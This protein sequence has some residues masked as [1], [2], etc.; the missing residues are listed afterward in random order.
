MFD[1]PTPRPGT[2]REVVTR[3]VVATLVDLLVVFPL[4]YAGIFLFVGRTDIPAP[5]SILGSLF[6]FVFSVFGFMPFFLFR[7]GRPM[8]LFLSAVAVWAVYASVLETLFGQTIGKKLVGLVVV[9]EDGTPASTRAVVV[10]NAFRAIDG[11]VFYVVGFLVVVLTDRRQRVG[12]LVANTVVA[13]VAG[14]GE[15][16]E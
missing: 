8:L 13:G 4:F 2:E 5:V 15:Q 11:L 9:M 14:T 3:R 16:N 10:R 7:R 6:W 12:D 1:H